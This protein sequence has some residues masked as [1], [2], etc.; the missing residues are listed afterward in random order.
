MTADPSLI[1][2]TPS[3]REALV[4][5][6]YAV[7]E[8]KGFVALT[9]EAGTGKTSLLAR[10]LKTLPASRVASSL[11]FN[12]SV[13]EAE[14]LELMLMDFGFVDIPT[15][16]A[17]LFHKFHE[18]LLQT[19]AAGKIAV[20]VVDEAHRLKPS[21]LEEI[22]L[23]SNLELPGQ[24]LLQVVLAGQPELID[25]LSQPDLRQLSQRISVRLTIDFLRPKEVEEYIALRWSKSAP[26][27]PPFSRAAYA[28]IVSWSR[29]IPRLVNAICD[30]ALMLVFAETASAVESRHVAEACRDLSLIEHEVKH[31]TPMNGTNKPL[32][33]DYKAEFEAA[34]TPMPAPLP[35]RVPE[36]LPPIPPIRRSRWLR[37]TRR[38]Q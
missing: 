6:A 19:H 7:L 12:P 29:G 21:V 3:H 2:M 27:P 4:G 16:K 33:K 22:R 38:A 23:L 13:N 30:N 10:T 15:N 17:Q 8:R 37:I 32:A 18:F 31:S 35:V 34:K 36:A 24:K 9:G 5:L 14:F 1:Y 11:V 28:D 25:V 26:T 20:V